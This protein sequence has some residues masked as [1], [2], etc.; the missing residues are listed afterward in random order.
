MIDDDSSSNDSANRPFHDVLTTYASRRKLIGGSGL[1]IAGFLAGEPL[2]ALADGLQ[3]NGSGGTLMNFTP[4]PVA[5]GG[6]R[7]PRI[8]PEY[9]YDVLIP[10]GSPIAPNKFEVVGIGHDGMWYCP[11]GSGN[12]R[13]SH[14]VL[15]VN[16]EYGDNIVV[17]G[18]NTPSNLDEVRQSQY[19]HGVTIVEIQRTGKGNGKWRTTGRHGLARRIHVNT[20]VAFSGPVAASPLL[21]NAANNPYQGTVNNCANG[22][23]PWG[24]C[25]TCEENFNA[26]FGARAPWTPN[27]MQRRYG[28]S[29]A[30]SYGWHLFDERF[31]LSNPDY[32]NEANRF[33]WI[34][35]IDPARPHSQPVKR[36]ALGRFKHEGIA[37]VEG[38]D[39]RIV[40]YM[41]DDE[42]FDY[43]YKFVSADNWRVMRARGLSPL[44]HGTLYVARF[45]DAG[46]GEW[47]ELTIDHPLIA[48]EFS[49][50]AEVLT[51]ARRAADLVGATPMDRPEWTTVA[52]NGLVYCTLTNNSNRGR[53]GVPGATAANPQAPNPD[54]HIIRWLDSDGHVGLTFQW[55]IFML[56]SATHGTEASFASPDGLWADPDGRLFIQTDGA[57]HDGLNDQMLVADI[58]TGEIRRLFEG[59]WGAEVTGIAVTPDRKTMFVNLQH[60][61]PTANPGRD[62]TIVIMRKDGG[63]VGS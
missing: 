56:A 47:L 30:S 41:G 2:D 59:V 8:A 13:N 7:T 15:V 9:T 22:H 51:Y 33:G 31:D 19:M 36:T 63:I 3:R 39:G 18:K 58:Y 44:D 48:A 24:T 32:A 50:Q 35:E 40:G 28:M 20:P 46:T 55:E 52:P 10:Y 25:L 4:V 53:S 62:A 57:Q 38:P 11:I 29:A 61:D 21:Q 34:V 6:G 27:P 12:S 26:Y 17:L 5:G 45:D 37:I 42:R 14:G 1:A 16:N 60:P 23:T 43:I 49:T 54:G